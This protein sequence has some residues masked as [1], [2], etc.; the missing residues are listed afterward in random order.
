LEQRDQAVEL[1]HQALA[2]LGGVEARL[3]EGLLASGFAHVLL[4][5]S[6]RGRGLFPHPQTYP[7]LRTR[8]GA[9]AQEL[10][11]VA[12]RR[13]GRGRGPQGERRGPG[14][15]SERPRRSAPRPPQRADCKSSSSCRW[16]SLPSAA[17]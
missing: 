8:E 2:V 13:E 16:W 5:G 3:G 12:E 9:A 6:A 14:R 4:S 11:D 7:S 10:R 1:A 17:T 15:A